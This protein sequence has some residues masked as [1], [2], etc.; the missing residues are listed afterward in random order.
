[1]RPPQQH[2]QAACTHWLG[3]SRRLQLEPPFNPVAKTKGDLDIMLSIILMCKSK[4]NSVV[5]SKSWLT[6][7]ESVQLSTLIGNT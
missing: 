5:H 6:T 2:L 4:Q 3:C 1:M 7:P